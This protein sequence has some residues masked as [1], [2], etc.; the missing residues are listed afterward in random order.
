MSISSVIIA[1]LL[2]PE[3]Y[4]LYSLIIT[5]P[6]LFIG[7]ADFGITSAITRFAAEFRAKGRDSDVKSVIKSGL[8]F[9][10][11]VG[12]IASVLCFIFSDAA[13][14]YIINSP[15][16]GF[17]IRIASI[18]I[19]F[20][21][22]FDTLSA[23]FIGLDKMENNAVMMIIRAVT[24]ILLSTLLIFL[25][26]NVL[27]AVLGHIS[28]YIVSVGIFLTFL[29]VKLRKKREH[30]NSGSGVLKSMLKYGAPLYISVILGL[31][32]S[33][34]QTIILAFFTS[35]SAIGNFQ[36]TSFFSTALSIIIYPLGALFP[37][38]SKLDPKSEQLSQLF[39]RSVKYTALLL[40]PASLAI[41]VMSNDLV[42]TFYG[43]EYNL[44]PTFVVFYMLTNL[45]AGFGS[46]VFVFLFNG[47]GR[48]DIVLK[49]SLINL[50]V[51]VPLAPLLISSYGVI[52]LILA[53]LVSGFCSLIYRLVIATKKLNVSIDIVSSAKI[54]LASAISALLTFTFIATSP[55]TNI[56]NLIFGCTIFLFTYITMLPTIG[57]LNGTDIDIFRMLFHK[58]K[59]IWPIIRIFLSY[60]TKVLE[61]TKRFK[62]K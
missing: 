12:V 62:K 38:F 61:F 6:S 55:F 54:Y 18:L 9:E 45:F 36:V 34:Y 14:K 60:E 44:A 35:K 27:G 19:L 42:L 20:Q 28:C 30:T 11:T 21:I 13:A 56:I 3:D 50:I 53:L 4:G 48:T 47:V 2:G 17:Y 59:S 10:L 31:F 16:A 40:I 39:R 8:F 33:Q 41:V 43:S 37:A 29:V 5:V 46:A 32:V 24:K 7:L 58:I 49:A 15:E 52:G 26:F 57:I 23:I 51:F 1:Q 25:S 22:L